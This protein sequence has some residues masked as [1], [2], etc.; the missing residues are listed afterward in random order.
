M[1]GSLRHRVKEIRNVLSDSPVRASA[2]CTKVYDL[3]DSDPAAR[4]A[5]VA[6]VVDGLEVAAAVGA[7]GSIIVPRFGKP[8]IPDLAPVFTPSELEHRLIVSILRELAPRAEE[9]GVLIMLEPLHRYIAKFLRTVDH[10]IQICEEVG[11]PNVRIMIDIFQSYQEEVRVPDSIRRAGSLVRHVHLSD[12]NR[13]LPG[14]GCTDFRSVFQALRDIR[15]SD[16]MSLECE[17]LGDKAEE[18][19][20]TAA[21][22]RQELSASTEGRNS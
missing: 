8:S 11:S 21:F 18:L 10:A 2:I 16:Y 15:F 9:L 7:V 4:R 3:L 6:Q 17:V 13:R 1:E 12:N 22:M 19:R 5:A 20:R 14:F